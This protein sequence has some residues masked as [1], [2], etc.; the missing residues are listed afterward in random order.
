M[1]KTTSK[2]VLLSI[3]TVSMFTLGMPT[4]VMAR[5][6]RG[7]KSSGKI[8][9]PAAGG[10]GNSK[11]AN[12]SG[13]ANGNKAV[14]NKG[15]NKAVNNS[16]NKTANNVRGGNNNVNIDNSRDVNVNVDGNNHGCCWGGGYNDDYHP[17]GTAVAVTAAAVT[18]AAVIGAIVSPNQMP[19]NCVQVIRYNTTYM[20]CGS[21]WYQPQY[22]GSNVT[23]V[24][25]NQP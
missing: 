1:I 15:A 17:I 9:R 22:Q 11:A 16:G 18:T 24:V 3:I 4:E 21:T 6:D 20:Q 8:D 10:G 2:S 19:S 23:Y 14:S 25:V 7:A 12:R 13:N 5:G